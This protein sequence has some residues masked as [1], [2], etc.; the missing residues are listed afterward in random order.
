MGKNEISFL[1]MMY[2][3]LDLLKILLELLLTFIAD[4]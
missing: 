3:M 4:F 2:T 1:N